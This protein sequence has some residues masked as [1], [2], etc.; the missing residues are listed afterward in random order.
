MANTLCFT[1]L[2]V[3]SSIPSNKPG[4]L[5]GAS[6]T[7]K[8]ILIDNTTFRSFIRTD[9]SHSIIVKAADKNNPG[10]KVNSLV[11]ANCDGNGALACS[12]CKGAGVNIADHFDGKFKAGAVCWLCRGK[13]EMLCGDCNGA[14]FMG[15]FMSTYDE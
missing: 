14:G 9:K 7:R 10:A 4:F 5:I 6:N 1:P 13:K 8:V 15:G 11:C 3:N 12:Q 2:N